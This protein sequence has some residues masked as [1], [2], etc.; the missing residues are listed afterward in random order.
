MSCRY[1]GL[2]S[3]Q[4]GKECRFRAGNLSGKTPGKVTSAKLEKE[5]PPQDLWESVLRKGNSMD[6]GPEGRLH[7][8]IPKV[9]GRP[10]WR[11]RGEGVRIGRWRVCYREEGVR[12][13]R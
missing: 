7:V 2:E 13:G 11:G 9:R 4:L 6:Q 3:E 5:E 10:G 8:W 12:I 1:K